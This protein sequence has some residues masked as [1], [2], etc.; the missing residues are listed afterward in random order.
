MG[1]GFHLVLFFCYLPTLSC[2]FLFGVQIG[3]QAQFKIMAD[4]KM[5]RIQ[6][7]LSDA[8]VCSRRAGEKL[9]EQGRVAVNGEI[10]HKPGTPVDPQK[11]VVAVDGNP[12]KKRTKRHIAVH[13]PRGVVSTKSDEMGR[14]ILSDLLPD[15]WDDL[16]PVGRLDRESEGLI[17]MTNDGDFCLKVTHPRYGIIKKYRVTVRGKVENKDLKPL[18]QGIRAGSELLKAHSCR[19][20]AKDFAGSLLEIELAEGKNREIRRMMKQMGLKVENLRRIQIGTIAIGDL[21]PGKWRVLQP[22]EI[23]SLTKG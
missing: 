16:Y 3:D 6:K 1:P 22:G 23:A 17:L 18:L 12:V 19:V 2:C 5:V 10:I 4:S 15:E 9:V 14:S 13:K 20:L 7:Y 21:K 11:D 8:G